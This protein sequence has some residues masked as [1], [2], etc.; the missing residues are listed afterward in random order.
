MFVVVVIVVIDVVVDVFV[1]VVV[2]VLSF[3]RFA[4]SLVESPNFSCVVGDAASPL[5]LD[6]TS[7]LTWIV[8]VFL[9]SCRH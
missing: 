4:P 2:G 7:R 1:V 9:K 3:V 8:V 6:W 5:R